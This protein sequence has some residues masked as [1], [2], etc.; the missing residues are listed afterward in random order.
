[1]SARVGTDARDC[2]M[3]ASGAEPATEAVKEMSSR[4]RYEAVG[5]NAELSAWLF[6]KCKC[7]VR[8][9]S[10]LLKTVLEGVLAILICHLA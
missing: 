8:V 7:R 2:A 4:R 3:K 6:L 1:M 9:L 10:L 5:C